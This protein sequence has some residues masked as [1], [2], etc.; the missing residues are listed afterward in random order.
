VERRSEAGWLIAGMVLVPYATVFLPFEAALRAQ[1]GL[2]TTVLVVAAW[3]GWRTRRRVGLDLPRPVRVGLGLYAGAALWGGAVGLLAGNPLRFVASQAVAMALLP[4]AVLVFAL[5]SDVDG[6]SL[7][8]GLGWAAFAAL[9]LH[10]AALFWPGLA[11]A[12]PGH[13]GFDLRNAVGATAVAPLIWLLGLSRARLAPRSWFVA[14]PLAAGLLC[15]WA[16]SRGAWLSV[17]AGTVVLLALVA[18]R[19]TRALT[20]ASAAALLPFLLALAVGGLAADL[21][22]RHGSALAGSGAAPLRIESSPVTATVMETGAPGAFRGAAVHVS[23]LSDGARGSRL[24]VWVEFADAAGG[25]LGRRWVEVPGTGRWAPWA[26]IVAAPPMARVLRTGLR[27]DPGQGTWQVADVERSSVRSN[28]EGLGRQ[29]LVR[30]AT[31]GRALVDP[32]ADSALEYRIAESR[33]VGAAWNGASLGRRLAGLGLGATFPFPNPSGEGG[34]SDVVPRASYIHNFYLFLG[35]KLGLAGVGALAGLA[36]VVAWTA[37]SAIAL[38]GRSDRQWMLAAATAAWFTYL[39]WSVTSPEIYDFRIAP[40]WGALI[41]A[42]CRDARAADTTDAGR[43][44]IGGPSV[45]V[46]PLHVERL[47]SEDAF[48]TLRP[49]WDRLLAR[50][51]SATVALTWEWLATWWE[52]YRGSAELAVFT[53]REA[54]GSLVGLAPFAIKSRRTWGGFRVRRVSLLGT[55]EPRQ[56]AICSEYLDLVA[57]TVHE[58]E[59]VEALAR[60]LAGTWRVGWDEIVMSSVR[61]GSAAL[62]LH[63]AMEAMGFRGATFETE[64]CPTLRLPENERGVAGLLSPRLQRKLA[65]YVRKLEEEGRV[66]LTS[67]GEEADLNSAMADLIALHQQRWTGRH[68]RGCFA[69]ERFT[70]FHRRVA[71]ALLR[72]GRLALYSLT[73]GGRVV[74]VLYGFR[75]GTRLLAYQSGFDP[76]FAPRVSLGLVMLGLCLGRAVAEGIREWDFLRGE[77]AYKLHWATGSH[78]ILEARV[79]N[80]TP[81]AAVSR[82]ELRARRAAKGALRSLRLREQGGA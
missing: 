7:L 47:S 69:S 41:V 81:G 50:S 48:S 52:L 53:F 26:A 31:L 75:D 70:T 74:Y 71:P 55:G 32:A 54:D 80:T 46:A 64:R 28:V 36:L 3:R 1:A 21:D 45:D 51:R 6:E 72:Q 8:G 22:E 2:I 13:F 43:A 40:L 30:A 15:L 60:H 16:Q 44:S 73:V 65:Y 39:V 78:P 61:P 5:R 17:L 19:P 38:R 49:E 79:W 56:E 35:L 66:E 82:R 77:E 24:W 4:A 68:R 42:C 29:L 10:V 37:R 57:T 25:S 14:V 33:A 34:G 12:V 67:C 20:L 27:L 59:V 23:G 11:G 62:A 63:A 76:S 58:R 9:A 18:R